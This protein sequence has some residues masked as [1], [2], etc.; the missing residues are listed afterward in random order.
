MLSETPINSAKIG[1]LGRNLCSRRRPLLV[2]A[3]E[4]QSEQVGLRGTFIK[5]TADFYVICLIHRVPDGVNGDLK[6]W[7]SKL[8]K[9][10]SL[11]ARGKERFALSESLD[12]LRFGFCLWNR[13]DEGKWIQ[14]A[15]MIFVQ[16]ARSVSER[17]TIKRDL[18]II[19]LPLN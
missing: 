7:L 10:C 12:G 9:R 19:Q 3:P 17:R 14:S 16:P 5:N 2:L 8:K 18:F 4:R 11:G 1:P 6:L 13:A 15:E